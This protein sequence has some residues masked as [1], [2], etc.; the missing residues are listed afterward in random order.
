VAKQADWEQKDDWYWAGPGGWT[1]CRILLK[2]GAERYEIWQP[3]KQVPDDAR[4]TLAAA[5]KR[6]AEIAS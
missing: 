3:G 6:Y 2:D 1:I 4:P 5:V